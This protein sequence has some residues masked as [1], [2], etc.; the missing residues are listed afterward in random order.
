MVSQFKVFTSEVDVKTVILQTDLA[1]LA[2][3]VLRMA[4]DITEIASRFEREVTY[5]SRADIAGLLAEADL[6]RKLLLQYDATYLGLNDEHARLVKDALLSWDTNVEPY[7]RS[8][9]PVQSS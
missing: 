9:D 8:L 1:T 5:Y 4:R 2:P 3:L 7:F 6:I